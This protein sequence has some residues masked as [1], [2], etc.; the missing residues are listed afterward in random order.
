MISLGS[1]SY[2]K[3]YI[4]INIQKI[5]K[6][7]IIM[8]NRQNNNQN[9]NR[10]RNSPAQNGRRP[11]KPVSALAPVRTASRGAAIRAQRRTHDDAQRVISQYLDAPEVTTDDRPRRANVID[12]SPRLK[13]IGL[14]GQDSGGSKN[15]ILV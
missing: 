6:G 13:V 10:R 4:T 7:I 11:Q 15:M 3:R 5:Q 1:P 12:D 9:Q 2:L 8:N 14:G